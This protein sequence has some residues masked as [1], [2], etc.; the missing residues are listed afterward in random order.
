MMNTSP[1]MGIAFYGYLMDR[2]D[3]AERAWLG[4]ALEGKKAF[5]TSNVFWIMC[6]AAAIALVVVVA[7]R[8]PIAKAEARNA[9]VDGS[10]APAGVAAADDSSSASDA[11]A[12]ENF[13]IE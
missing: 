4:V 9:N 5:L 8:R 2:K 12:A 10:E 1:A 7:M 3:L 13:A 6:L 11:E